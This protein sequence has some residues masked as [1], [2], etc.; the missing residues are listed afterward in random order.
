MQ[1]EPATQRP[2]PNEQP[3]SV[4]EKL[5]QLG[6]LGQ[7]MTDRIV[8]GNA[9]VVELQRPCVTSG[10]LADTAAAPDAGEKGSPDEGVGKEDHREAAK[11]LVSSLVAAAQSAN[12][13]AVAEPSVAA[14]AVMLEEPGEKAQ[15]FA[16]CTAGSGSQ[17]VAEPQPAGPAAAAGAETRPSSAGRGSQ[18]SGWQKLDEG[19]GGAPGSYPT[20][21]R[22]LQLLCSP[23]FFAVASTFSLVLVVVIAAVLHGPGGIHRAAAPEL[24][25]LFR[26]SAGVVVRM[27]ECGKWKET[28]TAADYEC[29]GSAT[30]SPDTSPAAAWDLLG[31]AS[32][33][34]PVISTCHEDPA[35]RLKELAAVLG[36]CCSGECPALYH[37]GTTRVKVAQLRHS[38]SKWRTEACADDSPVR[39]GSRPCHCTAPR[40]CEGT[41]CLLSEEYDCGHT[42]V[43]VR[44]TAHDILAVLLY[45]KWS[46][47]VFAFDEDALTVARVQA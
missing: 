23:R 12:P 30:A 22:L 2:G 27:L 37:S 43:H 11:G 24:E 8:Q 3:V 13:V 28:A 44:F 47:D 1:G 33:P 20:R 19:E 18:R 36:R 15:G 6:L 34:D 16:V 10:T 32:W 9:S 42:Q 7:A 26:S 31:A 17:G 29:D 38:F 35:A 45:N 5:Q 46:G 39:I 4:M 21:P 41:A 25:R 40:D 14:E